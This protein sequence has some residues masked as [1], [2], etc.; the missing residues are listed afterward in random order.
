M[1]LFAAYSLGVPCLVIV[2]SIHEP[3]A[4]WTIRMVATPV[5]PSRGR[6]NTKVR[7]GACCKS[8]TRSSQSRPVASS[9]QSQTHSDATG[10]N[11]GERSWI[12]NAS[13]AT[14]GT[15]ATPRTATLYN[16]HRDS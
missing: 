12:C 2:N 3:Q 15:R 8:K 9:N 1:L 16:L 14:P 4:W 6:G 7:P 5:R 10:L 11:C 13:Y